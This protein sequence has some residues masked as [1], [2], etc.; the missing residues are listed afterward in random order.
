M[1]VIERERQG[2]RKIKIETKIYREER[3]RKKEKVIEKGKRE[4]DFLSAV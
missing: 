1:C 4:R 2:K 3:K